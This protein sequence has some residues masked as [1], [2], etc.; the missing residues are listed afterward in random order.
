MVTYQD[1]FPSIQFK[2]TSNLIQLIYTSIS[3]AWI[4]KFFYKRDNISIL[5][6]LIKYVGIFESTE[7][8]KNIPDL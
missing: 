1:R 2:E 3:V 5:F 7:K 6:K 4:L 8:S